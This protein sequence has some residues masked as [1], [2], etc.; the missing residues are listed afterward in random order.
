MATIVAAAFV[1]ALQGACPPAV[2]QPA[3]LATAA[4]PTRDGRVFHLA[5]YRGRWVFIDYW[6]TWCD[7]CLKGLP[8]LNSLAADP[9]LQ[10]IGLSDEKIGQQNWDAFLKAH[11]FRYPV[12]LV[13][14]AVL[15]RSIAPSVFFVEAR[16]ISYLIRP[17]GTVAGRFLGDVSAGEVHAAMARAGGQ[18]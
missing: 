12:A 13:D 2:A 16:P 17:D 15:P 6:A 5:D 1:S 10:V 3:S 4:I 9:S 18:R 7:A 11:A 8:V 14:R